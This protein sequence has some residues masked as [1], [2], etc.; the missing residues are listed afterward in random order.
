MYQL[1]EKLGYQILSNHKLIGNI[2]FQIMREAIY[3]FFEDTSNKPEDTLLFYYS[4]HDI[5]ILMEMY[6]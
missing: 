2:T 1:L 6:F 3:D 5:P 4:G